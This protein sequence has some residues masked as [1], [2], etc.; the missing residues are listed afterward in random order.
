MGSSLHI[1]LPMIVCGSSMAK[2]SLFVDIAVLTV[3]VDDIVRSITQNRRICLV[4]DGKIAQ[5]PHAYF[6]TTS[7]NSFLTPW[8]F[9]WFFFTSD[10]SDA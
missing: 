10:K 6:M 2:R 1:V 4:V 5:A 3:N 7:K 8:S 9:V